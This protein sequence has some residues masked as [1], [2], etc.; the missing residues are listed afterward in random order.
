MMD[1]KSEA[2]Q[3]QS[4]YLKPDADEG[5]HI[6]AKRQ[7]LN[8]RHQKGQVAGDE[9][10]QREI[11]LHSHQLLKTRLVAAVSG[12]RAYSFT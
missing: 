6:L 3:V 9:R 2:G 11:K 7:L 10:V 8:V 5:H 12:V 1:E 4:Q